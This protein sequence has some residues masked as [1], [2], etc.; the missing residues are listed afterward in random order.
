DAAIGRDPAIGPVHTEIVPWRADAVA[1]LIAA[2][3]AG[4]GRRSSGWPA[5]GLCRC[6]AGA[7]SYAPVG[8]ATATATAVLTT[9]GCSSGHNGAWCCSARRPSRRPDCRPAEPCVRRGGTAADGL[10]R[11][12]R[13]PPAAVSSVLPVTPGPAEPDSWQ[14]RRPAPDCWAGYGPLP[15]ADVDTEQ[16]PVQ[17]VA[18][19]HQS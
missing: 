6:P 15:A 18:P 16:R 1:G 4:P 10:H 5:A 14:H 3:R 9:S 2:I 13:P 7:A 11:Y 19:D 8:A 12:R 17:P